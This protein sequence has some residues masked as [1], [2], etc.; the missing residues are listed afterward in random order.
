MTVVFSGD[1]VVPA[2]PPPW[3]MLLSWMVWLPEYS[4][5]LAPV[6]VDLTMT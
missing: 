6:V 4:V 5:I 1:G 2:V 3:M